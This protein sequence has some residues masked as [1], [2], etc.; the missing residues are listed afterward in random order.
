MNAK[1]NLARA[2]GI[3]LALLPVAAFAQTATVKGHDTA[4]QDGFYVAALIAKDK[5]WREKWNTD[6]AHTPSFKSG[7]HL[8]PGDYG[9]LLT[10]F[11]GATPKNGQI[12]IACDLVIHYADGTKKEFPANTCSQ[13]PLEQRDDNL[14]LTGLEIELLPED[15]DPA[16][17]TSFDIGITD[18]NAGIRLPLSVAFELVRDDRT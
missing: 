8:A 17:V 5:D 14:R 6:P 10:F 3:A 15:D 4:S 16:G 18:L 7:A 13:G 12:A 1:T 9:A 11:A 2:L